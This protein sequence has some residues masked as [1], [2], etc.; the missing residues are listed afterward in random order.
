VAAENADRRW[1]CMERDKD[2]AAKAIQRIRDHVG[3]PVF[4]PTWDFM[5]MVGDPL[6]AMFG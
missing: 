6:E 2:Y 1:I 3:D 5:D 4:D